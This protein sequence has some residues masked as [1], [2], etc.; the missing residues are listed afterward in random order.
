MATLT[1]ASDQFGVLIGILER[2]HP[3]WIKVKLALQ[4]YVQTLNEFQAWVEANLQIYETDLRALV[5]H[6]EAFAHVTDASK[7]FEFEPKVEPSF[8]LLLHRVLHD[9]NYCSVCSLTIDLKHVFGMNIP[10]AYREDQIT[11]RFHTNEQRFQQF[12]TN[13]LKEV[14]VMPGRRSL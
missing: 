1:N 6:L 4:Y 13:L 3:G 10:S 7:N 5:G 11:L 12:I 9:S 2:T 14:E 8:K